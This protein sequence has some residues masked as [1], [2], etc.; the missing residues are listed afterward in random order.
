MNKNLKREKNK[1][2]LLTKAVCLWYNSVRMAV[3]SYFDTFTNYNTYVK[4]SQ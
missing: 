3:F 1:Q 2:R 4:K